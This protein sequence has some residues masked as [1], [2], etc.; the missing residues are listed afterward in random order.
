MLF[1]AGA[2][3]KSNAE[4]RLDPLCDVDVHRERLV[5]VLRRRRGGR[6]NHREP[7]KVGYPRSD[8]ITSCGHVNEESAKDATVFVVFLVAHEAAVTTVSAL[9]I[10][11]RAHANACS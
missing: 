3:K 1:P 6:R 4:A 8:A 7:W 2:L 10:C 9:A 5:R 11:A